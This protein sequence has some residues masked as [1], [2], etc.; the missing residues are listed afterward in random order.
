MVLNKIYV[1]V[2]SD[3]EIRSKPQP[4]PNEGQKRQKPDKFNKAKMMT[5]GHRQKSR[6]LQLEVTVM[7]TTRNTH[8]KDTGLFGVLFMFFAVKYMI[9]YGVILINII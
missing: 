9:S 5:W 7:M 2:F 6:S 4:L 1:G 8:L 3:H